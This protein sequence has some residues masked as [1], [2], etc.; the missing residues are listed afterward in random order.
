MVCDTVLD[1]SSVTLVTSGSLTS[2]PAVLLL[3][4][5]DALGFSLLVHR[6]RCSTA[7]FPA[8]VSKLL[9]Q[10]LKIILD[11]NYVLKRDYDLSY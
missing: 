5:N 11:A 9:L 8:S 7:E 1:L 3:C 6:P 2:P 10:L 4:S